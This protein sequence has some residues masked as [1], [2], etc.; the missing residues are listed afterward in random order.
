[1]QEIKKRIN[2]HFLDSS[3]PPM[4]MLDGQ[5]GSGKT[6]FIR[7][8]YMQ[9]AS[10]EQDAK[11]GSK[12]KIFFSLYGIN[13]LDDFKDKLLSHLMLGR[14]D[15]EQIATHATSFVTSIS[16]YLGSETSGALSVVGSLA[17]A[18]KHSYLN[19]ISDIILILDDLERLDDPKLQGQILGECL[20]LAEKK[21][22]YVLVL[23]NSEAISES[24]RPLLEKS[25]SELV[26][27]EL[28][29]DEV[30]KNC[31]SDT[32]FSTDEQ[33][34]LKSYSTQFQNQ[35]ALKRG[36]KQIEKIWSNINNKEYLHVEESFT[37]LCS[38][39]LAV[40]Y[41]KYELNGD[42][43][44]LAYCL[45]SVRAKSSVSAV[46]K[47]K[48]GIEEVKLSEKQQRYASLLRN[49]VYEENIFKSI[50]YGAC[51]FTDPIKDLGL[52]KIECKY[53]KLL[54]RDLTRIE[55]QEDFDEQV[56]ALKDYLF[57]Q[58]KLD[59]FEWFLAANIYMELISNN[60]LLVEA[61][62]ELKALEE[63]VTIDK[64]EV[65][66]ANRILR[67]GDTESGLEPLKATLLLIANT[68]DS[69]KSTAKI[70]LE[71]SE[72][73]YATI[74]RLQAKSNNEPIF[75]KFDPK[76]IYS[77]IEN[78]WDH[79][80]IIYFTNYLN[81]RYFNFPFQK[82]FLETS[83]FKELDSS[84]KSLDFDST[85]KKGSLINLKL[86]VESIINTLNKLES[87][88]FPKPRTAINPG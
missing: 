68:L 8:N 13:S 41:A 83:F 58:L 59:C 66:R 53:W 82:A 6:Y 30:F 22:F 11:L 64:F 38:Q 52:V 60:Y 1:M 62:T 28:T 86:Q 9:N 78:K 43:K 3:M 37:N 4:V 17:G 80:D 33:R 44:T 73:V 45:S 88:Y 48:Q 49:L 10:D 32:S 54:S 47:A 39:V 63:A 77:L 27:F 2:T 51:N 29:H 84:L 75:D 14:G 46:I 69:Q 5:W 42:Y 16:K 65:G 67:M 85:L 74:L 18:L 61:S 34:I 12:K 20:E 36:I 50:F 40:V 71:F 87:S 26:T 79:R 35:R 7:N 19:D 15:G 31:I 55:N 81:D 76:S 56:L 57:K 24:S 25:F 23:A 70:M 72:D 21:S